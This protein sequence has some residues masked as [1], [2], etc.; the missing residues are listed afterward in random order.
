ML[1][2]V[3]CVSIKIVVKLVEIAGAR[4]SELLLYEL[5]NIFSDDHNILLR[6]VLPA[7][8]CATSVKLM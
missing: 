7:V 8:A 5:D 3:C 2:I 4:L 6:Q 1:Y